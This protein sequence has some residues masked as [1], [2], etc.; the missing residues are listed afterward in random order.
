V[1]ASAIPGREEDRLVR[2]K[3]FLSER[4]KA[5]GL[6]PFVL[7]AHRMGT[8]DWWRIDVSKAA[9]LS[10]VV[11]TAYGRGVKEW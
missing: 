3:E 7:C 2:G 11:C 9:A 6:L 4:S 8:E 5:D 10:G 1:V